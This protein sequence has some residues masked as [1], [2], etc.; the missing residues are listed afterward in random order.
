M[1]KESIKPFKICGL[2][3]RTTSENGQ[4]TKD[5]GEL[6][7]IFLGDNITDNIPNK[8]DNPIFSI[9]TNY[10]GDFTQPYDTILGCEVDSLHK[11]L[12]GIIGQEFK[13]GIY[14]KFT[15]KGSLHKGVVHRI[16][17]EILKS[18]IN[19]TYSADFEVFGVKSKNPENAEVD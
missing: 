1:Q 4:S 5:I 12:K 17:D 13:G 19:R 14:V 6:W 9:Y 7:N 16:W 8:T 18:D 10:Q 3:V 15:S 11:I 2:K